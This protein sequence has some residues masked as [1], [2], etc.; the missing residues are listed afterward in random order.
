MYREIRAEKV[1][2]WLSELCQRVDGLARLVSTILITPLNL[3]TPAHPSY[4]EGTRWNTP[5]LRLHQPSPHGGLV[6]SSQDA[7]LPL[8][9]E[10]TG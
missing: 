2:S 5:A 1:L 4:E 3:T 7:S 6:I 9:G 8:T 10:H